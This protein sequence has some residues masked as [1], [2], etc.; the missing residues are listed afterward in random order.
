MQNVDKVRKFAVR[1]RLLIGIPASKVARTDSAMNNATL[2]YIHEYGA[3]EANIPAR[4]FLMPGMEAAEPMIV[5]ELAK[6]LAKGIALAAVQ[7]D[8]SAGKAAL[9]DGLNRAG[10]KAV[11]II[12]GQITAG[13]SPPLADRTVYARLH[14]R[15]NRRTGPDLKPLFD[16]GQLLRSITYVIR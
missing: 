5:D 2:A 14:R 10:L 15:K 3:P 13:L 9:T 11:S 7:G 6:A 4:P 12:Q 16:T 1:Q 8:V